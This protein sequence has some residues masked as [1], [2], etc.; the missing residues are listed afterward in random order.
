MGTPA[1]E[2][3]EFRVEELD[4][5]RGVVD[6][7]LGILHERQQVVDDLGELR[8][9]LKEVAREAVHGERALV[10]VALG[11][12]VLV[13]AVFRDAA[14]DDLDAADLD[15]A[16]A[17]LGLETRG[18]GVQHDLSHVRSLALPVARPA[19]APTRVEASYSAPCRATPSAATGTSS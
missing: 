11:I 7:H 8:L 15:D 1:A 19:S 12:D 14:A 13:K 10:A 17:F 18:L 6:D 2:A 9:V 3:T 16:V 5:E 4:V